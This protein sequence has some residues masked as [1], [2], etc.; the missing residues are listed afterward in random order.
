MSGASTGATTPVTAPRPPREGGAALMIAGGLLLGTIGIFV[1]EAGQS[2][3]VTVWCR[4]L[5]GL[6]ALLAWGAWRGQL[7]ELRA[8][9]G[10]A[11]AAVAGAGVLMVANWA[12]FF[13]AIPRCSIAVSTVVF[14]LQPFWL[15]AMGA[16]WLHERV[17]RTQWAAA[18]VALAGL[19]DRPA[20]SWQLGSG[21]VQGL[22]LSLAGSLC[23]AGAG[24]VAKVEGARTGSYPLA[25]GQAAVGAVLLAPWA[26]L[27]GLPAPGATATWAWLVGLGVLHTG[28]AYVIL[29]A[30]MARLATG[31]IAVLQFVYPA[32]AVVVDWL[33]YS[34]PLSPLQG[35]GVGLI[36]AALWSLRRMG[37]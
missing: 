30:G 37:R 12:F 24:L 5:F 9:R 22:L 27:H 25:A 36:G 10:R 1:E 23:Y 32:T 11:L 15:M 29:Y 19:A 20:G 13:A 8:L 31:Q 4:C 17:T 14:H 16:W 35:L 34:R 18:A 26:L 7:G 21:Y 28:L 3:G 2:P 6:L 33:V